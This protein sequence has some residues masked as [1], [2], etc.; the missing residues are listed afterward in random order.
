MSNEAK[1]SSNVEI[2]FPFQKK[3]ITVSEIKFK[4]V[5]FKEDCEAWSDTPGA[6]TDTNTNTATAA[7]DLPFYLEVP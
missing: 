4:D 3:K 7:R 5:Q 6:S 1:N 2:Y